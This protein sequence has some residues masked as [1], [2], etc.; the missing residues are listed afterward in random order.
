[1]KTPKYLYLFFLI[2]FAFLLVEYFLSFYGRGNNIMNL[3]LN[4]DLNTDYS[5][6]EGFKIEEEEGFIQIIGFNTKL[7]KNVRVKKILKYSNASNGIYCQFIDFNNK[8]H[9]AAISSN[10]F[11]LSPIKIINKIEIKSN[12]KWIDVNNTM[13]LKL[14][15]IIYF[16][17]KILFVILVL[18][19]S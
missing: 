8:L 16:I 11:N 7:D 1:M 6:L 17:I 10:N 13:E 18:I 9:Y 12:L 5:P 3:K 4:Y 14:L 19:I 15:L 2:I